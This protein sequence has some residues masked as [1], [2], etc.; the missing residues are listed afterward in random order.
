MQR[1]WLGSTW[2]HAMRVGMHACSSKRTACERQAVSGWCMQGLSFRISWLFMSDSSLP[3]SGSIKPRVLCFLWFCVKN[4]LQNSVATRV[5]PS[6][7]P[8][9]TGS[10]EGRCLQK[11]RR[12]WTLLGVYDNLVF[13]ERSRDC[14]PLRRWRLPTLCYDY[15]A[16]TTTWP[17]RRVHPPPLLSICLYLLCLFTWSFFYKLFIMHV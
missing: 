16:T 14:L 8:A 13:G 7:V 1:G 3:K 17:I 6:G 11:R 15:A 4:T 2:V 9:H 12:S 5:S 10:L